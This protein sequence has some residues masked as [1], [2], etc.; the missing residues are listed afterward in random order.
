MV[1]KERIE[2]CIHELLIAIG[3]DPNRPGLIETPKRV[4]KMY[5]TLCEGVDKTNKE[6]GEMFNKSFEGHDSNLVI[7]KNIEFYSLCEHHIIPFFGKVHIGY[8]PNGKVL[9]LSKFARIVKMCS[10]RLQLQEKL[11]EDIAEAVMAATGSEDVIVV[12]NDSTHLCVSMR[13]AESQGF[14]TTTSTLKGK[15]RNEFDLR[16]E[17]MELIK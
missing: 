15:F 17:F 16:S 4:A 9:G 5:A 6:I 8:L 14:T 2:K 12:I 1:D 13:G 10:R 11:G 3:E 7:A